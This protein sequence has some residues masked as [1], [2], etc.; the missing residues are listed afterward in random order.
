MANWC[1]NIAY[2]AAPD[3]DK[4][5]AALISTANEELNDDFGVIDRYAPTLGGAGINHLKR[6]GSRIEIAS[7]SRDEPP[8]ELYRAMEAQGWKVDALYWEPN[9]LF[10]GA[11]RNGADKRL[12]YEFDKDEDM[13]PQLPA[14][15]VAHFRPKIRWFAQG[16]SVITFFS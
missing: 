14:E 2:L 9:H 12:E 4:A 6:A 15:V 13:I 5:I 1:Q 8:I 10:W 16:W 11:Y 3:E 7:H